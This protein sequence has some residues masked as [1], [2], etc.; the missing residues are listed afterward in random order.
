MLLSAF[1]VVFLALN[2]EA[3]FVVRQNGQIILFTDE[4]HGITYAD[5]EKMCKA[6]GGQ[7]PKLE[8]KQDMDE[9][10]D[11]A[12][13]NAKSMLG[14]WISL[15]Q[16]N[17]GKLF[18]ADGSPLSASLPRRQ[19][20]YECE[21]NHCNYSVNPWWNGIVGEV[22]SDGKSNLMCVMSKGIMQGKIELESLETEIK[23]LDGQVAK[24]QESFEELK[25]KLN[26]NIMS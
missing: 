9:L 2:T 21:R 13:K 19:N 17:S 6:I 18:W 8:S 10:L 3:I 7:F 22:N 4:P 5:S 23:A 20:Q 15:K 24:I 11:V 25:N 16:D 1:L 12:K 26:S 14:F